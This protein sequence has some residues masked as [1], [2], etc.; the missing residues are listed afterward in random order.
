MARFSP[1]LGVGKYRDRLVLLVGA[2]GL[3]ASSLCA[4]SRRWEHRAKSHHDI[5]HRR[6]TRH[7]LLWGNRVAHG[8]VGQWQRL[9]AGARPV[10]V[11]NR[12]ASPVTGYVVSLRVGEGMGEIPLA[13]KFRESL[14]S[15]I[16][17]VRNT[18]MRLFHLGATTLCSCMV[19]N[20]V[21]PLMCLLAGAKPFISTP[22][23]P[24]LCQAIANRSRFFA[25]RWV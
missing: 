9:L 11:E 22:T 15:A 5:E 24:S 2:K 23:I 18:F 13:G 1:L 3:R 6:S 19:M 14:R 8:T 17:R 7:I 16:R 25:Q 21:L 10:V 20:F 4:A 12:T